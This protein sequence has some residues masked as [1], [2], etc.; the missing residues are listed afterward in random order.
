MNVFRK[1]NILSLLVISVTSCQTSNSFKESFYRNMAIGLVGGY[2][3]GQTKPTNKEAYGYM[4]GAAAASM[5]AAGTVFLSDPSQGSPAQKE[6]ESLKEQI[7]KMQKDLEPKLTEQGKSL[8]TSPLPAE[9]TNLIEPGEWKRYK[10]DQW[11]QDP[12]QTNTWYRQVEMFEIIPPNP[13]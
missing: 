11:V 7:K 9:V 5:M 1:F 2:L 3:V 8:F 10:M 12:N 4:Y 13:R 6:N